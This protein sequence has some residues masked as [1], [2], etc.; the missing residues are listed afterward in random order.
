MA[1]MKVYPVEV[2]Y[3][4]KRTLFV[5]AR[6]PNGAAEKALT[7]AGWREATMYDEDAPT[8]PP[9]DTKVTKVGEPV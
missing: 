5:P 9:K 8:Y 6:K 1:H 7:E 4:I 3:V 2:E